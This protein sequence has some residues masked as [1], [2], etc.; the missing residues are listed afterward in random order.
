MKD[1]ECTIGVIYCSDDIHLS[2][3]SSLK[4]HVE[5][6]RRFNIIS[7]SLNYPIH[8]KEYTLK[9]YGDLRKSTDLVRF[10]FCPYCGKKIDWK[11]IR[12]LESS[13]NLDK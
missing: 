2:T 6:L 7:D 9:D 3:L 10:G 12:K 8:R 1:H 11:Y 4:G 5:E 13:T